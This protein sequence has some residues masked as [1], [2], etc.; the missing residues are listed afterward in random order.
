MG[1]EKPL[2]VIAVTSPGPDEGKSTTAANL[3]VA[4][5]LSG[6]R[7]L[8]VDGDLRR[9]LQHRAFGL[10]QNPGLTDVLIRSVSPREAARPD[11]LESL[12]LLP[13]GSIP[14]NPSELLGS[15]GMQ[16]LLGEL[17]REY[18]YIVID[19]PPTLPVTD[20]AVVATAADATILVVR[21]GM[22]EEVP[23][24]RAIDQLR[25]VHARIAGIVLTGI[26]QRNDYHYSY[27]TYPQAGAARPSL[28][29][30]ILSRI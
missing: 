10:V 20:A 29:S 4:L 2:Q 9:P 15:E 22:T 24:R 16:R 19:T 14:P 11:V 30:R 17:R 26:T 27:Y 18:E 23:M 3:A 1:A 8:L 6:S 13:S 25:R 5:A 28:R 12:D 7:T 21:S